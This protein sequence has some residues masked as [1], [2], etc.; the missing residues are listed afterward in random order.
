MRIYPMPCQRWY[1]VHVTFQTT[2]YVVGSAG[3]A[4]GM[5]LGNASRLYKFNIH[6][7][8]GLLIFILASIQVI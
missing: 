4:I 7:N 6:Y 5:W 1:D 3:W 2:G 8:V